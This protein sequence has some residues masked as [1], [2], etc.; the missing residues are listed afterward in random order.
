MAVMCSG[1]GGKALTV[2]LQPPGPWL[3][4][5]WPPARLSA[6]V[7]PGG[8]GPAGA[9]PAGH[10]QG[11]GAA[12]ALHRLL[13]PDPGAHAWRSPPCPPAP[14]HTY[15]A[16]S[17]TACGFGHSHAG[18]RAPLQSTPPLVAAA[19]AAAGRVRPVR[20]VCGLP[21]PAP[22]GA[23]RAGTSV[24]EPL[25]RRQRRGQ[26]LPDRGRWARG[27]VWPA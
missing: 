12:A 15:P 19:L 4:P 24:R 18:L 3:R 6:G 23:V 27:E 16:A 13:L 9:A 26:L 17:Q 11:A 5:G 21:A 8:R 2:L 10:A 14:P 1:G 20:G 7:A 25:V 22:H